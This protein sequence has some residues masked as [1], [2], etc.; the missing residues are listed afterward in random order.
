MEEVTYKYSKYN[1]ELE[2]ENEDE[3]TIFNTYTSKYITL[4]KEVVEDLKGE[5]D[6]SLGD[7]PDYLVDL[8]IFVPSI[9]DETSLVLS[10]M[11][12]C[13]H[14]QNQLNFVIQLSLRCN[15]RCYYCYQ[16]DS[17]CNKDMSFET[18]NE[19]IAFIIQKCEEYTS[20]ELLQIQWFR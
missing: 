19:V 14:E 3:V 12:K 5:T 2:T 6:I 4:E 8:G 9:L 17:L 7:F 11:H 18:M 16:K 13:A 1:I 10:K 15:Y 20:L